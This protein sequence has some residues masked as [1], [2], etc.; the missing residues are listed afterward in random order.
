MD[1]EP[2]DAFAV[3]MANA[4]AMCPPEDPWYIA[5]LYK[6]TLVHID[7]VEPLFGI[8][9]HGQTLGSGDL[10]PM[11]VVTKR[12]KNEIYEAG[13]EHKQAGLMAALETFGADAFRF[14]LVEFKRGR[15]NAMQTWADEVEVKAIAA[16]GG[17]LRSMSERCAQTLN[18]TKGGQGFARW[19]G[20]DAFR[21]T[22]FER[23]KSAMET[24]VA[25]YGDA[26]VPQSYVTPSGYVLGK[27][28]DAFRSVG[29]MRAGLPK[30]SEIEAWA[31][32]LPKWAWKAMETDEYK[33]AKRQSAKRQWEEADDATRDKW[34]TGNKE[35]HNRSEVVEAS[36]QARIQRWA[37]ADEETRAKWRAGTKDAMNRPEVRKA[38]SERVTAQRKRECIDEPEREAKRAAKQSATC[39]ARF[40]AKMQGKSEEERLEMQENRAAQRRADARRKAELE[41]LRTVWP[42]AGFKDLPKARREGLVPE[43]EDV[44]TMSER[45]SARRKRECIDEPELEAKRAAKQSATCDAKFEAKMQGRSEEERLKM[46]EKRAKEQRADAKKKAELERLRTVWPDAKN[47]DLPKARREGLIPAP[48][49]SVVSNL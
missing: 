8:T 38:A 42:E 48:A 24:Y 45:V 16:H 33:E 13:R 9:Y 12:W 47:S 44:V 7:P 49:S 6:I 31:E 3:L 15:R 11:D 32:S 43:S 36:R 39:D 22:A 40:E 30:Q 5:C 19:E 29:E 10:D 1:G 4:T 14:E 17:P 20:I 28:L 46:Q 35:A 26:L 27:R 37:A 23:F 18:L 34:C 25:E 21:M 2:K 41:R